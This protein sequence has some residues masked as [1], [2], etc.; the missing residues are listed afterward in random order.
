MVVH[1]ILYVPCS[2]TS[3]SYV[4]SVNG[5]KWMECSIFLCLNIYIVKFTYSLHL[6][7]VFKTKI[8][9]FFYCSIINRTDFVL[10]CMCE[11][12]WVCMWM[13]SLFSVWFSFG[14]LSGPFAHNSFWNWNWNCNSVYDLCFCALKYTLITLI[15]TQ[16]H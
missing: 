2:S 9:H 4:Q 14:P 11:C 16:I 6:L 13:Y 7:C 8:L 5:L 15:C 3:T 10:I 1:Q 12:V